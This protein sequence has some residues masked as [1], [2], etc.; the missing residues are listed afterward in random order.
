MK[1]ILLATGFL[2]LLTGCKKLPEITAA[3]IIAL[4]ASYTSSHHFTGATI[5]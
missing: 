3:K 5:L 1:N 4:T 2:M